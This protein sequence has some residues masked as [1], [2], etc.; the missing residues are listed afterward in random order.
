MAVFHL[1]FTIKRQI[2][3]FE[4]IQRIEAANAQSEHGRSWK[5]INELTGRKNTKR[6]ILK[7]SSQEERIKKWHD[8]FQK[9][10]GQEPLL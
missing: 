1:F 3:L 9:L 4:T 2:F 7:A 8:H 10:L 5:L 6:G